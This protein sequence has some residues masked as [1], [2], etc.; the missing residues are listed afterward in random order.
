MLF[1]SIQFLIFFVVVTTTY[2]LIPH[3]FRWF[4]LLAASCVFYAAF[5]PIYLLILF[6]T[7]VIDYIAGIQIEKA[8]GARRK[9]FLILSLVAN[10]G[11]LAVFKYYNFFIDNINFLLQQSH[12]AADG[13]DY[14][15]IALPIGLSFHTFQAMSYTIE[16]YRGNVPA[17]RNFGIYALYVMFYPQLVAGPI[18]RPQAVIHQFYEEKH[19]DFE[20]VIVGLERIL[21]G[22]F[23][24][25][26]VSDLLGI[27]VNS[28]YNH[29][30]S[31]TGLTLLVAT[32]G[33]A[34]Q[35]YCDFSGYSDIALGTAQVMGFKLMENFN[36]PYFSKSVTEFWRRWHI[37]L[38]SWLRD[39]LYIS[40]GGNR[41]GTVKTY[42]NLMLTMLLGG[43]WHGAS[44]NFVIWG[45]LNGAYL[46]LEK[47]F[48][49]DVKSGS[50]YSLPY[51]L[52]RI[53]ITF[54][55]ICFTWVFF[56]ATSF[57][58]A[59]YIITH[60]FN[61]TNFWN[62]RIQDTGI[63]ASMSLG[64]VLLLLFEY[65]YLR[66]RHIAEITPAYSW[67][68]PMA[69]SMVLIFLIVGFGVSGGDQFIYFQF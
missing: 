32:Y 41:K 39:Y 51:K 3:R 29:H 20:R 59:F 62:L 43:L 38:S 44:W 36:L 27:Y 28:I 56:R 46:S 47:M 21:W 19:F 6:G 50:K 4:L 16:V 54:H 25:V 48:G 53:F 10:I 26:V 5:I 58:Q 33:F 67:K 14:L 66:K 30:E 22:L 9:S 55:L 17:E 69:F 52:L 31:N 7:I 13:L 11:V 1:N 49:V 65:L 42:R 57:S 2:F 18:E 34:F 8:E 64:V 60:I 15:R 37:S 23:K 45:F 61:P 24:K 12:V 40:L 35:I 68:W 63:F